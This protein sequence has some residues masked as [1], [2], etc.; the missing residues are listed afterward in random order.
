L[1]SPGGAAHQSPASTP[2]TYSHYLAPATLLS[3]HH[4]GTITGCGL[5]RDDLS[6]KVAF[7][8]QDVMKDSFYARIVRFGLIQ[9]PH[10]G[11][12]SEVND[13]QMRA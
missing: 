1:P 11:S 5:E 8:L 10:S 6:S 9:R 7:H 12:L 4:Y 3:L 13:P 2:V